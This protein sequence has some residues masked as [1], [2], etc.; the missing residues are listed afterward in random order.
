[1]KDVVL[2]SYVSLTGFYTK[3]KDEI[4]QVF[5]T[6][7]GMGWEFYNLDETERYGIE[8]FAEQYFGP[9]TINESIA[10]IDAEITS[11]SKKG[12]NIPYVSD[13]KAAIGVNTKLSKT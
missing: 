3:T 7:H 8:A 11:G 4:S 2:G 6:G 13:I 9:V 12:Q 10:Y 5:T 1:M